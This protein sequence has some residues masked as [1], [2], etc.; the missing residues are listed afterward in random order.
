MS[1]VARPVPDHGHDPVT[2]QALTTLVA[3]HGLVLLF[4]LG[5]LE[6]IGAPIASVPMLVAIGAMAEM[7]GG[8]NVVLMVLAAAAGGLL[9]DS[10]LFGLTRHSGSRMI[11][12]ACGLTS[13]PGSC[14]HKVRG[15]LDRLGG[16]YLVFAE[17]IP[18]VG[19]LIAPAAALAGVRTIAFLVEDAVAL[20]LWAAA[21]TGLGW[22]FSDRVET[23]LGWLAAYLDWVVILG[24]AL[25]GGAGVWR[26]LRVRA[27]TQGHRRMREAGA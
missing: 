10:L 20:V 27:H 3:E 15:E 21:Y 23:V 26:L 18:G 11:D 17:F 16:K 8:A 4:G 19:N 25:I 22:V 5:F 13:N 9:A 6:F 14:I 12:A 24:V 1:E 2:F 7:S